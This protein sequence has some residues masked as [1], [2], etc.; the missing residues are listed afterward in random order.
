LRTPHR[1]CGHRVNEIEGATTTKTALFSNGFGVA[2][3]RSMV[4]FLQNA[5]SLR[6]LDID[7]SD[8]QSEGFN[9]LLRALRDS[10]IKELNCNRCGIESIEID[11]NNIP[12][13]LTHLQLVGNKINTDGCRELSKLLQGVDPTLTN[14]LLEDNQ[15]D[16]EGVAILVDALQNN[17]TLTTLWLCGNEGISFEGMRL[18][19]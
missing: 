5:N 13:D 8:I 11:I 2:G 10:P 12:R 15:I 7:D 19:L 14:L 18:F 17:T 4:P 16:D 1:I 9:M 3:L 6:R